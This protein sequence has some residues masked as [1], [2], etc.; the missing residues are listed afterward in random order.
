VTETPTQTPTTTSTVTPTPSPV[1]TFFIINNSTGDRTV[2]SISG[3]PP[4]P[5]WNLDSGSYPVSAGQTVYGFVHS[6]L[7]ELTLDQLVVV[8]GGTD[9]INIEI[10]KNSSPYTPASSPSP[11][12]VTASPINYSINEPSDIILSNDI[13]VFTITNVD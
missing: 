7:T 6:S 12:N 11:T 5:G 9:P 3:G 4:S 8:F 2:T 10:T 1:P 13:I